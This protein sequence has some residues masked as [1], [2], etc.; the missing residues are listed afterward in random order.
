MFKR[1]YYRPPR[2]S[3]PPWEDNIELE[4]GGGGTSTRNAGIRNT[5]NTQGVVADSRAPFALANGRGGADSYLYPNKAGDTM[6]TL[7]L[8]QEANN[9]LLGAIASEGQHALVATGSTARGDGVHFACRYM[10]A[11]ATAAGR[12]YMSREERTA[13]SSKKA[14]QLRCGRSGGACN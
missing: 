12:P 9:N 14:A 3:P 1:E 8:V 11:P 7:S 6:D 5:H 13:E 10:A 4:I 2:P